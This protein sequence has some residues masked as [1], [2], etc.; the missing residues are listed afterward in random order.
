MVKLFKTSTNIISQLNYKFL[1]LF[2]CISIFNLMIED[3]TLKD[4]LH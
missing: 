4:A 2:I 1:F 3:G